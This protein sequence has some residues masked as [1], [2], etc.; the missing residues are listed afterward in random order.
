[1]ASDKTQTELK[2]FAYGKE[3]KRDTNINKR[4]G[5]TLFLFG[6]GKWVPWK[7]FTFLCYFESE[8]NRLNEIEWLLTCQVDF[9]LNNSFSE[10]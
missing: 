10:A 5:F 7:L 3:V 8:P 4:H 1:M 2:D 6:G 9:L